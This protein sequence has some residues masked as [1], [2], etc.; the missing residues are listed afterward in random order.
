MQKEVIEQIRGAEEK[1][2]AIETQ[3][4]AEA[5]KILSDAEKEAAGLLQA[6]KSKAEQERRERLEAERKQK[7]AELEQVKKETV[8]AAEQ[9]KTSAQ[10][11]MQEA[12]DAVLKAIAQ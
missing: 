12:V 5:Q 9:M 11:H 3:A 8:S 6:E 10:A 2:G 4:A 1:A 7:D